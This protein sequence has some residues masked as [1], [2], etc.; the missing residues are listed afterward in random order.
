M[1]AVLSY[2]I[3]AYYIWPARY[4]TPVFFLITFVTAHLYKGFLRPGIRAV[5][6][7]AYLAVCSCELYLYYDHYSDYQATKATYQQ[8]LTQMH[9]SGNIIVCQRNEDATEE[10]QFYAALYCFHP[11]LAGTL[12]LYYHGGDK[13]RKQFMQTLQEKRPQAHVYLSHIPYSNDSITLNKNT[14][15]IVN[16]WDVRFKNFAQNQIPDSRMKLIYNP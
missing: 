2:K 9:S 15:Y 4:Y 5:F 12:Q 6:L 11:E 3:G 1:K 16:E 13:F 10:I 14:Y 8:L 7:F